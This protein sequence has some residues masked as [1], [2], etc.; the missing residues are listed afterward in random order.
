MKSGHRVAVA[1]LGRA[2]VI[3]PIV[4]MFLLAPSPARA[5]A[6]A[7]QKVA[8][9]NTAR[10]FND[11]QETKDLKEKLEARRQEVSNEENDRRNKIKEMEDNLK[12]LHPDNPQ[13][14][15]AQQDLDQAMADFDSWGKVV[16]LQAERDQKQ[17]MVMLFNKIQAAVTQIAKEDQIDIVIA[18]QGPDIGDTEAL[19]FDQLRALINQKDVLYTSKRADI[20][21]E[22]LTL[23]DAQYTKDKAAQ[24]AGK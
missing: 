22:V 12:E 21:D 14:D 1:A 19:T 17:T 2:W 10:I 11:M 6:P 8:I 15:K 3:V 23:L 18:D 24:G 16:R 4:C 13:Y 7:A 9:A 20:S 5:D